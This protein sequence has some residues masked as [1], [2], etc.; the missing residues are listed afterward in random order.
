M[1]SYEAE[2]ARLQRLLEEVMNDDEVAAQEGNEPS[3]DDASVHSDNED[4]Y[5]SHLEVHQ[6]E[7]EQNISDNDDVESTASSSLSFIGIYSD[8]DDVESTASSSLSFI[9]KDKSSFWK[10]HPPQKGSIRTRQEN[11]IK[12]LSG[13]SLETRNRKTPLDIRN[14]FFDDVITTTIVNYTNEYISM[15]APN[16][17]DQN[18]AKP[19][20]YTE[21][22]ALI[23]LLYM[24]GICKSS[25]QNTEDIWRTDG[26][27]VE[28]FHPTMS[29][30][31]F[32]FL[33][34]CIRLDNRA[35]RFARKEMDKHAPIREFFDLFVKNC[36]FLEQVTVDIMLAG[37]GP[38]Y[39]L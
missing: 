27:G 33:L 25:R 21:I 1:A 7:S 2:Q 11:I 29:L 15:V 10:K 20:S 9:G 31:R 8:N 36:H 32:R 34:R 18:K 3:D 12:R 4:T 16:F 23:G 19:T 17:S 30:Q 22:R 24:I 26:Y 38:V 28:T 37:F 39:S 35:T 6:S 14:Y 13:P 5:Q